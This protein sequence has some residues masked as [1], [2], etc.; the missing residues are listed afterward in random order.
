M[1]DRFRD[2]RGGEQVAGR[3]HRHRRPLAQ[4]VLL[5]CEAAGQA[6]QVALDLLG[7]AGVAHADGLDPL[8]AVHLDDLADDRPHARRQLGAAGRA[9]G[10]DHGGDAGADR[11]QRGDVLGHLVRAGE[12]D[13]DVAGLD[14]V[15]R[16][17]S[18][19][20]AAEH[21]AGYVVAGEDL[22]RLECA[23]RD[24]DRL[25]LR[26]DEQVGADQRHLRPLVEPERPVLAQQLDALVRLD[27]REQLAQRV[28]RRAVP[29]AAARV[30]ALVGDDH[31]RAFL[32]RAERG[33]QA[34]GPGTEHHDVG[35]PVDALE[36]A[37]EVALVDLAEPGHLADH[38][39]DLGPQPARLDQ[40]LVV[41]AD[42]QELVRQPRVVHGQRV[43]LEREHHVLG[44][45]LH[46]VARRA[47]AAAH[48]RLAVDLH[49][50]VRAVAAHAQEAAAAV[51]LEGA[52]DGVDACAVERGADRVARVDRDLPAVEAEG[53]GG[54]VRPSHAGP[55]W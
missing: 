29:Q 6:E 22:H 5:R 55:G 16:R 37:G 54:R 31:R 49:E 11:L 12:D 45:D 33:G 34:R 27:L 52:G 50:A 14:R 51:V 7:A 3:V 24:H 47:R 35:V 44:F 38:R 39:L 25:G 18:H 8:R 36:V 46:P 48:A 26:H 53:L 13:R 28:A 10:D 40:R 41:E 17:E 21:H 9:V 1:G 2:G 19:G 15:L 20:S 4:E 43:A 42:R 32:G 30:L 23:G